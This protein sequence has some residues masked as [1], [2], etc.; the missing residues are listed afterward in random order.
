M[1]HI[2][3][4]YFLIIISTFLGCEQAIYA[5]DKNESTNL[6]LNSSNEQALLT[7]QQNED[8]FPNF[9]ITYETIDNK[10]FYK[11]NFNESEHY[12]LLN[13]TQDKFTLHGNEQSLELDFYNIFNT[14]T[15]S[16]A[17]ITLQDLTGD[18]TNELIFINSTGGTGANGTI[19]H[20]IDIEDM[21]KYE[22]TDYITDV[23]NQLKITAKN[24][25]KT[26]YGNNV[27]VEIMLNDEIFYAQITPLEDLPIEYYNYKPENQG[28]WH[29]ADLKNDSNEIAIEVGIS[30]ENQMPS[31]YI[32][33]VS[34]TLAFSKETQIFELS[35]FLE[36]EPIIQSLSR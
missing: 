17:I 15:D 30:L 5:N 26:D 35:E 11:F 7:I 2:F 14:Q 29:S 16:H 36:L 19:L 22:V 6:N 4:I 1:K 28:L 25:V 31:Q 33:M 21:Q 27:E 10:E 23:A 9:E 32:C 34:G 8:F 20:I 18:D 13:A 24:F 12:F 3:S